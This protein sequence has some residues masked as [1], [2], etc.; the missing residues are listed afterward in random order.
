[1]NVTS[2]QIKYDVRWYP[3]QPII[4]NA[5]NPYML[6]STGN[7]QPFLETLLRSRDLTFTHLPLGIT[8][9]LNFALNGRP[10]NTA[11]TNPLLP[12]I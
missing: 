7:C 1:M 3:P 5:G 2:M 9:N 6:D 12:P 8:N 4:G 11:N 10:F